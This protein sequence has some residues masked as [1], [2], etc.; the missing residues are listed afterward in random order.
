[1]GFWGTPTSS[2]QWCEEDYTHSWFI[3]EFWNTLSNIPPMIWAAVGLYY[4]TYVATKKQ[5]PI[6]LRRAYLWPIVVFA[7][8]T[9]FHATLTYTGQLLDEIPMIYGTLYFHYVIEQVVDAQMKK[10]MFMVKRIVYFAIAIAITTIMIVFRHS[11]LPLQLSY[12]LL[13]LALVIRT[14]LVARRISNP[15]LTRLMFIA[16]WVYVTASTMWT[17]EQLYCH[18]TK[19]FQLHSWWHVFAGAGTYLWIQGIAAANFAVIKEIPKVS[20]I[21][22]HIVFIEAE[23]EKLKN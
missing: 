7:G 10:P 22:A 13:V 1:M 11:P 23:N 15:I 16:F 21:G 17:V 4:A 12:S 8:S 14:I 20:I 9:C 18:S 2:I 3:A 5:Q 6:V 19:P